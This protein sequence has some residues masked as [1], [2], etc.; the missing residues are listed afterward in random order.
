MPFRL[1]YQAHDF[2]LPPGEFVI[3]R[4]DECQLAL[5]DGLVS[6][7]HALLRVTAANVLVVDLGSRNGV[8]VNGDRIAAERRVRHGDRI[9]IGNQEMT[10]HEVTMEEGV[11]TRALSRTMGDISV[12]EVQRMLHLQ[13]PRPKAG[14]PSFLAEATSSDEPPE[15]RGRGSESSKLNASWVLLSKVAEK[16][17]AMGRPQEADRVLSPLFHELLTE[18]R[19]GRSV[20]GAM[21]DQVAFLAIRIAEETGSG[22]RVNFVFECFLEARRLLPVKIVDTL[23]K[24]IRKMRVDVDLI[25]DYVSTM[26]NASTIMNPNERFLLQ[27][28]EG[29][30]QLV[31]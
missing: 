21:I 1:R 16:A 24:T 7:R 30:E 29:M 9:I 20:D 15:A 14:V 19:T 13:S 11:V 28:V 26:R 6:R 25:R 31:T 8:K 3:G 10:L 2:E 18:I 17:L 27:R 5:D 23:Y 22:D 12:D 4:S